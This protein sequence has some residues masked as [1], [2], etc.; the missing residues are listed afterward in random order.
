MG[1]SGVKRP[2]IGISLRVALAVIR[3]TWRPGFN[4]LQHVIV[5]RRGKLILELLQLHIAEIVVVGEL[6]DIL[7]RLV[8]GIMLTHRP[9]IV[10]QGSYDGSHIGQPI[11][12]V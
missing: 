9:S 12:Y 5:C 6:L 4:F 10:S 1:A 3:L 8:F 11:P 7:R 2:D